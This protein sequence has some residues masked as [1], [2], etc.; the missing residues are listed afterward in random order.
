MIRDHLMGFPPVLDAIDPPRAKKPPLG[1]RP[2]YPREVVG[3]DKTMQHRDFIGLRPGE[4]EQMDRGGESIALT[5]STMVLRPSETMRGKA[6]INGRPV[7]FIEVTVP[8][9]EYARRYGT[10]GNHEDRFKGNQAQSVAQMQ[11]GRLAGPD[12]Y[13]TATGQRM[14]HEQANRMIAEV[15]RMLKNFTAPPDIHRKMITR[16]QDLAERD[17]SSSSFRRAIAENGL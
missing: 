13:A 4:V 7:T 10:H 9:N 12:P 11:N 6:D 2:L 3:V 8:I 5:E 17:L 15:D 1:P 16:L 14:L